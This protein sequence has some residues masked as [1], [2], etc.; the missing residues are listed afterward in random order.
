MTSTAIPEGHRP[1]A[2]GARDLRLRTAGGNGRQPAA[3]LRRR[4]RFCTW[5]VVASPSG[6]TLGGSL[7]G[8]PARLGRVRLHVLSDLHL[9]HAP[10]AIPEVDA[11]VLVLAGDIAPGG[12]GIE[13]MRRHADGRPIVY[14]AGNHEFYGQDLP[15]LIGRLRD[16]AVGIADPRARERRACDRRRPLPRL[17]AVERLRLT[18]VR[19]TA[20]T[21]CAS[22]SASS[23]T[24]GR[25][26][27][28][29][30]TAAACAGHA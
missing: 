21:R 29:S 19:R 24:T 18:P 28:R 3:A 12:A 15:G 8:R 20:P 14:V 17:L 27:P 16:A 2:A 13:W 11:D 4:A 1:R 25:S 23:T 9:E 26:A 10:F 7:T 22:A 30:T 5:S 6:A